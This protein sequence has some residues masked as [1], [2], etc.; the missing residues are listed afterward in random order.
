MKKYLL[1]IL[2]FSSLIASAQLTGIKTIP[3]DYATITAA[4]AALN[5]SGVGAGG[6]TF[7]I[8]AGYTETGNNT[9]TATGTAANPSFFKKVGQGQTQQLRQV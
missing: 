6:V 5:A 8:A 3:G 7:N 4:L 1:F 9:I 2:T